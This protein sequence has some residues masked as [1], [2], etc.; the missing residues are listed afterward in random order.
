ME[1]PKDEINYLWAIR[2]IAH[3]KTFFFTTFEEMEHFV[4]DTTY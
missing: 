4:L 2:D 3:G 1:D